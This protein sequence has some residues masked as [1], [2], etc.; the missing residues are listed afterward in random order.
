M[1]RECLLTAGFVDQADEWIEPLVIR[2]TSW[3]EL[4][5]S[6]ALN[7]EQYRWGSFPI[8]EAFAAERIVATELSPLGRKALSLIRAQVEGT[9]PLRTE[10]NATMEDL[11]R[12]AATDS[13]LT[14]D[15]KTARCDIHSLDSTTCPGSC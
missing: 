6:G 1:L 7:I 15:R 12:E 3:L 10:A 5:N 2:W 8:A 11:E 4:E 13:E 14:R 9:A